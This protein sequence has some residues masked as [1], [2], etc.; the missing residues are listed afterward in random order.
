MTRIW[1]TLFVPVLVGATIAAS[2]SSDDDAAPSSSEQSSSTTATT[3]AV[4][5]ESTEAPPTT[6]AELPDLE[7]ALVWHQHQPRYPTVDGVVTRPWVRLH[8]AK[9]YVDMAT[10]VEEFPDLAVTINLTPVL[11]DQLDEL[12]AGARDAYWV[13]AETPL[14]ELTDEQRTFIG[15]RFFDING[16]I[17]ETMPRYVELRDI[18]SS[19]RDF[20]DGELQDLRALFHLGWIDPEVP[21]RAA[22][23]D[24]GRDFTD[25]DVRSILGLTQQLI[26]DT[27]PVHADL[28]AGEQ[29]EVI[30]TPL[31]HPILPLIADTDLARV[32]DPTAQLPREPFRQF[33]D[34]A[35]HVRLG[36]DRAEELLG[37][38]PTGMWPGEGAVA[39]PVMRLFA[40]Q[41]VDWVATGEDVLAQSLGIG[42]WNRDEN[43]TVQEAELLYRPWRVDTPEGPVTMFFRDNRISDLI[44]FEYSGEDAEAAADDFIARLAGIREQLAG[45]DLDYQ[46]LVSVILDGENAWENYPND[47]RDFLRALDERLTTTEWLTTTT[48]TRYLDE[49]PADAAPLDEVFPAAWFTPNYSIWIGESEEARA[50]DLLRFA[51]QELGAAE[52]QGTATQDQLDAA[53]AAMRA[54][55]GSDWFWWYGADQDSGDDGYF[56]AAYREL[57]GQVYD[58][59]GLDRPRWVD[60]P[61]IPE[62]TLAPDRSTGDPVEIA[63]DGDGSG[64]DAA[65]TFVL[66]AGPLREIGA[67]VSEDSLS[68]RLDGDLRGGAEVYL[69]APRGTSRRGTT[70]DDR[71]LG[72]DATHLVRIDSDGVACVSGT[73]LPV[74][75]IGRYPATCTEIVSEAT[76]DGIELAV[77][78][79]SLGALAAGDRIILRAQVTDS[80]VP[81]AGAAEISVPDIAGF[82]P[83][84]TVADPIDDDTGIGT[85]TYPTDD[86]FVDGSYD[87]TAFEAG[88]SGDDLVFSVVVDAPVLNPWN[89]PV[90]LSIQSFDIYLDS[91][92]GSGTGNRT[93]LDGRNGSLEEG[94]GW[95]AAI[96]IEG[97]DRAVAIPTGDD[98]YE[99]TKPEIGVSVLSEGGRVTV[100]VPRAALPESFDLDRGGIAV[101]VMSQEGFPSPGVRRVRDIDPTASQWRGGGAPPGT[102]HTRIYD[103]LAPDS[104]DQAALLADGLVPLANP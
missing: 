13:A 16:R 8:A 32:G 97:W 17:I 54:A 98:A 93:L 88:T 50:W 26:D 1:R 96:A 53:F 22:F 30:T 91:D 18:R 71:L 104:I 37:R 69:R 63:I 10:L 74:T 80:L 4:V 103:V 38:R 3:A 34:A 77:P 79:S 67:A 82:D 90:S 56:D 99:E 75:Q 47:G 9:D 42:S 87:L 66:D 35:D 78:I 39:Q 92:P 14:A 86:A 61:I 5:T 29:L 62:P 73:L 95:E 11:L 12:S 83:V 59:L 85:Y 100:R 55:E 36:L 25:A 49:H 52:R 72:F 21:E 89:S 28:W 15:D 64:W 23:I 48:P 27:I 33:G 76:A 45:A 40:E 60:V 2:C 46:P 58:G 70:I 44:G 31:A 51:R 101:V 19:G 102:D 6:V 7:V 84:V 81:A 65:N 94:N 41:G 68:L 20:T 24:Q 43:D 57:L